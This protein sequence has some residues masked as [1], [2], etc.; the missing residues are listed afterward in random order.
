LSARRSSACL[1]AALM[2]VFAAAPAA[3]AQNAFA[4]GNNN[5]GQ[6]GDGTSTNRPV[7][8]A[9]VGMG[10]G[11]TSVSGGQ[12]HSL[13]VMN[14][15]AYAWG[16]NLWG[17]LGTGGAQ[18]NQHSPGAVVGGMNS[19][20]TAVSAGA[21]AFSLALPSDRLRGRHRRVLLQLRPDL[22]WPAVRVG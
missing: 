18:Q 19:G 12:E 21:T 22:F 5:S 13:T 20:V 6:L 17:Q 1:I 10:S 11:V 15:A 14:G 9:V 7:P 2:S 8:T 4:W 16:T 3:R